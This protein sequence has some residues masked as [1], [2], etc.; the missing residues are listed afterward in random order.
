MASRENSRRFSRDD[1]TSSRGPSSNR[2]NGIRV[3]Y[4][5]RFVHVRTRDDDSDRNPF[6]YCAF[7][8]LGAAAG[9][10]GLPDATG[11]LS[12]SNICI[13]IV[14]STI[15][16]LKIKKWFSLMMKFNMLIDYEWKYGETSFLLVRN[17]CFFCNLRQIFFS[18]HFIFIPFFISVW[19][20]IYTFIVKLFR[21]NFRLKIFL[22]L[23]KILI[24]TTLKG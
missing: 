14:L 19:N 13:V 3:A 18:L 5:V 17:S 2:F 1:A 6:L 9:A 10:A 12:A 4:Y 16:V 8:R 23:F 22:V 21:H 7:N 11:W 15:F 24:I 20:V